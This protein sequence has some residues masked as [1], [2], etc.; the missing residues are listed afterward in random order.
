MIHVANE[1]R[2]TPKKSAKQ[3]KSVNFYPVT[4]CFFLRITPE[5]FWFP[6][7]IPAVPLGV[8]GHNHI[9]ELVRYANDAGA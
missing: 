4:L 6:R 2:K 9:E 7:E 5:I 3:G 1:Q 8:H